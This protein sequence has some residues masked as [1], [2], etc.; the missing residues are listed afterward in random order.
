L[1]RELEQQRVK[2]ERSMIQRLDDES[3][4]KKRSKKSQLYDDLKN[5]FGSLSLHSHC[6]LGKRLSRRKKK[7]IEPPQALELSS[8]ELSLDDRPTEIP[9]ISG[10]ALNL[11]SDMGVPSRSSFLSEDSSRRRRQSLS[12][13]GG[14]R[15]VSPK[16]ALYKHLQSPK[17]EGSNMTDPTRPRRS[18]SALLTAPA[19]SHPDSKI[20]YRFECKQPSR[21]KSFTELEN[22][23]KF[24]SKSGVAW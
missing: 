4:K 20:D 22:I 5:D 11:I 19:S 15:S 10:I 18:T 24:S 9:G 8:S 14:G 23:R 13:K 16:V 1:D 12:P 7:S 6:G 2:E 17:P 3:G 21:H